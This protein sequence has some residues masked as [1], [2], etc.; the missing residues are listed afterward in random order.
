MDNQPK[1]CIKRL[2]QKCHVEGFT[3]KST[4]LNPKPGHLGNFSGTKRNKESVW[5]INKSVHNRR[6]FATYIYQIM[7]GWKTCKDCY[8]TDEVPNP[9]ANP[10]QEKIGWKWQSRNSSHSKWLFAGWDWFYIGNRLQETQHDQILRQQPTAGYCCKTLVQLR[11]KAELYSTYTLPKNVYR[12]EISRKD[13]QHS[14][15]YQVNHFDGRSRSQIVKTNR[16]T[17]PWEFSRKD[18]GRRS[19]FGMPTIVSGQSKPGQ[20]AT[21]PSELSRNETD[22]RIFTVECQPS[23]PTWPKA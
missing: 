17:C 5:V 19:R 8:E 1:G 3:H 20:W 21:C 22:V 11:Q 13:D 23:F 6:V 10:T 15:D 7:L 2:L 16:A 14:V 9:K 12:W 18:E 4:T